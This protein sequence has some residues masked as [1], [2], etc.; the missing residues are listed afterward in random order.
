MTHDVEQ[1]FSDP[2]CGA[3]WQ[4]MDLVLAD[5]EYLL[6]IRDPRSEKLI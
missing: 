2:T 5:V 3:D 6:P 4:D 1:W